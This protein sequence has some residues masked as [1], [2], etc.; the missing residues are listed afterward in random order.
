MGPAIRDNLHPTLGRFATKPPQ[1]TD[2][3]DIDKRKEVNT[4]IVGCAPLA[5]SRSAPSD[6]PV[7]LTI[8]SAKTAGK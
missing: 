8:G 4:P 6:Q 2:Q 5:S 1:R 7:S 3:Q